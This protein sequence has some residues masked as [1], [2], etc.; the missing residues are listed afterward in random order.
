MRA[1][2]AVVGK[3]GGWKQWA[4][5]AAPLLISAASLA[6]PYALDLQGDA[7]NATRDQL[8]LWTAIVGAVLSTIAFAA[9]WRW[10]D[11]WFLQTIW[12][13]AFGLASVVAA[14]GLW[15]EVHWAP[16]AA[17]GTVAIAASSRT[18]LALAVTCV[19]SGFGAADYL[20]DE[21]PSLT[22]SAEVA[23]AI[24]LG[25]AALGCLLASL[26]WLGPRRLR[27][28]LVGSAALM[29]LA[30][31]LILS[32]PFSFMLL[33]PSALIAWL[34]L[35]WDSK[36]A[37]AAA[38]VAAALFVLIPLAFLPDCG[39]VVWVIPV[40]LVIAVIGGVA[41]TPRVLFAG[42][43]MAGVVVGMLPGLLWAC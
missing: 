41:K 14:C 1:R 42:L 22:R 35:G 3:A 6:Y 36:P 11:R 24:L 10:R 8:Y 43:A 19:V 12:A 29:A 30:L 9:G 7:R 33:V 39:S 40:G 20:I 38:W 16:I 13:P 27:L 37:V 28:G 21:G 5:E 4:L 25:I 15:S 23:A 26:N 17:C 2:L 32:G 31:A 18:H 34:S